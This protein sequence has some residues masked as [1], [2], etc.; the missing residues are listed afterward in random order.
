[1]GEEIKI[2]EEEIKRVHKINDLSGTYVPIHILENLIKAYKE[3]KE[4]LE[5]TS[6]A[7]DNIAYDQ[8]PIA[9]KELKEENSRIEYVEKEIYRNNNPEDW[10]TKGLYTLKYH[11]RIDVIPK[12]LIKEKIEEL[13]IKITYIESQY[14]NGGQNCDSN[15]LGTLY[16]KQVLEELLGEEK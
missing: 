11:K 2:L 13:E 7:L 10:D 15:Y 14:T 8:I 16:Q 3:Q 6:K 4:C 1:M 12:S 9:I 5:V